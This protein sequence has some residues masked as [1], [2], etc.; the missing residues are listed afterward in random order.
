MLVLTPDVPHTDVLETWTATPWKATY[1]GLAPK[2]D[3]DIYLYGFATPT[4]SIKRFKEAGAT[5]I[6]DAIV[7]PLEYTTYQRVHNSSNRPAEYRELLDDY[8]TRLRL[9]DGYF[10]ASELEKQVLTGLL[11]TCRFDVLLEP[12]RDMSLD[13]LMCL[14]PV[15]YSERNER[16]GLK[17]SGEPPAPGPDFVWNGGLWNHYSP[18]T[19]V[20]GLRS[21][22]HAGHEADLWFLYPQRGTP[23]TAYRAVQEAVAADPRLA[24]HVTFCQGGL[25]LMGRIAVMETARAALCLYE[26][27]ALWDL[28]PPMRLRETVLY[29]LPVVAP[30]R[31]AL[32]D[33]VSTQGFGVTTASLSA[34]DVAAAMLACLQDQPAAKMRGAAEAA[35]EAFRYE[36]MMPGVTTWMDQVRAR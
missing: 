21:L 4:D 19:A 12:A 22:L 36:T 32:G 18:V 14:L 35:A 2:M 11:T 25:S 31:S 15:G 3:G 30:R 24:R 8:L 6:F 27:H 34:D 10:V 17:P 23:T 1:E 20:R 28:C 5:L 29:R 9:A 7:W 26:P 13:D 33:I 16:T